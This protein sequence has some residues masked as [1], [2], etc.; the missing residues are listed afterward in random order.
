MIMIVKL[1]SFLGFSLSS[2]QVSKG[3]IFKLRFICLCQVLS[4]FIVHSYFSTWLVHIPERPVIWNRGLQCSG[5]SVTNRL[6]LL[7]ALLEVIH[8]SSE[9]QRWHWQIPEREWSLW[10]AVE[11]LSCIIPEQFCL[12]CIWQNKLCDSPA[13]QVQWTDNR[14]VP[15]AAGSGEGAHELGISNEQTWNAGQFH[16]TQTWQHI[17][18]AF[19]VGWLLLSSLLLQYCHCAEQVSKGGVTATRN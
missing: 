4:E 11:S 16:F 7:W 13:G 19:F 12:M 14:H 9:I 3:V 18:T 1:Y 8:S 15:N 6:C 2:F 10:C 17:L 5:R